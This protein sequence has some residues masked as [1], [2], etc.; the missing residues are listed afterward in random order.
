MLNLN[1]IKDWLEE[2]NYNN[3]PVQYKL[4]NNNLHNYFTNE[5]LKYNNKKLIKKLLQLKNDIDNNNLDKR[6]KLNDEK[7][8]FYSKYVQKFNLNGKNYYFFINPYSNRYYVHMLF[9]KLIDYCIT[10]N[11][12][13]GKNKYIVTKEMGVDL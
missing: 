8:I 7:L 13:D 12:R 2:E 1:K 10:N 6:D 11:L 5:N 4:N 3:I 9:N